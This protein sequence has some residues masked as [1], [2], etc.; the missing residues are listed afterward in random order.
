MTLNLDGQGIDDFERFEVFVGA[1][2]FH[3][4]DRRVRQER[5]VSG[6]RRNPFGGIDIR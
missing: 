6:Q 2:L 1:S 5:D 3:G 4:D